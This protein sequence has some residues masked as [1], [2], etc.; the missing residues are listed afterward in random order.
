MLVHQHNGFHGSIRMARVNMAAIEDARS[1]DRSAKVL[2]RQIDG[3]LRQLQ[4]SLGTRVNL[5]GSVS[6]RGPDGKH[7]VIIP[8]TKVVD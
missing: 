7:T 8:A 6:Q 1:V 5:D 3:L 2:A 4:Y